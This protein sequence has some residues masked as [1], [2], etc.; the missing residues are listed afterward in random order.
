MVDLFDLLLSLLRLSISLL[1]H[2]SP[3]IFFSPEYPTY[4]LSSRRPSR[5]FLEIVGLK[6]H[7][8]AVRANTGLHALRRRDVYPV[9]EHHGDLVPRP[10]RTNIGERHVAVQ[11]ALPWE[12]PR[13]HAD[14]S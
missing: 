5:H 2:N 9:G 12:G 10:R 14:E 13:A 3:P 7:L 4:N 6:A 11:C 8:D 1:V